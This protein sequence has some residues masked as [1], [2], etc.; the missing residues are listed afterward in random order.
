MSDDPQPGLPPETP[1]SDPAA[2]EHRQ[3][4]DEPVAFP[5][6]V[7]VLIGAVLLAI[8]G[9][10]VF[11]GLRY[12]DNTLANGII[13]ARHQPSPSASA[14]GGPPGEPAAG[15]SLMFPGESGDNVPNANP[16][17]SGRARAEMTNGP[18]GV[19]ATVRMW[20]RR[21]MMVKAVPNDAM[22]Y[23]NDTPVGPSTQ[24]DSPDEFYEF[25]AP[26]SYTVRLTAPGYQERTFT[27]TASETA[28]DEIAVIDVTLKK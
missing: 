11:T 15:A 20:A 16:A 17:V 18:N 2:R 1:Q 22:V 8:A 6:W 23:V 25:P 24:L 4:A 13:R 21:G 19:S 7:P 12:R 14:G 5:R 28:K 9:L 3:P 27:V 26:G 10:A